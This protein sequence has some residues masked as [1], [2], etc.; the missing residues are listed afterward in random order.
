MV[1]TI[2]K[3]GLAVLLTVFGVISVNAQ[4][5]TMWKID[6][7]HTSVNFSINHF[8]NTVTGN[9]TDFD[10]DIYFDPSNL[11]GSKADF[12]IAVKSINT[13]NSKR[14]DQLQSPDFF[15]EKTFPNM[16][17]KSIRFEKKSENEYLVH[18]KLTIKDKTR[19]IVLP[20]K[21]T[22][23]ME[24]PMMKGTIILGLASNLK[25]NRN[26]YGVGTGDWATT[27]VVGNEVDISINMELNRMK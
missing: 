11:K 2:K 19:N 13:D 18:G 1:S 6:K 7:A 8:F 21:V 23:Q 10:G 27:M 26:D 22:G 17:F 12:T 24:H 14:D 5:A 15:N 16:T 4:D 25:I 3:L 9:F 20:L